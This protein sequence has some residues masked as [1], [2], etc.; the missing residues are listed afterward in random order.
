MVDMP[1]RA[2]QFSHDHIFLLLAQYSDYIMAQNK[3]W[4]TC[5][6]KRD[7]NLNKILLKLWSKMDKKIKEDY[8][9]RDGGKGH[10]NQRK[11]SE[12]KRWRAFQKFEG[13]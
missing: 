1:K 3:H 2:V 6:K 13:I 11:R 8:A 12:I 9:I 10:G 5:L 4:K 7:Q